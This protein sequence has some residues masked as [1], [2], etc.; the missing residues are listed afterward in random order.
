MV[1]KNLSGTG[2]GPP[3]CPPPKTRRE[4]IL[5][6]HL[7]L[8]SVTTLKTHF[9]VEG[10]APLALSRVWRTNVPPYTTNLKMQKV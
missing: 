4:A 7:V 5:F 1:N 10:R 9:W 3:P 6:Y 2:S 8:K